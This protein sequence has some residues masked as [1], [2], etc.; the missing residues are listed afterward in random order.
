[1][2]DSATIEIQLQI[3]QEAYHQLQDE[4][5]RRDITL[6]ELLTEVIDDFLDQPP[7]EEEM[8]DTP[9]EKILADLREAWKET[10][11][12]KTYPAKE[13]L[14]TLRKKLRDESDSS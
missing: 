9:K 13:A 6:N 1:M 4:V 14:A 3:S 12:G 7:S 11:T 5:K 2:S 8:E 10:L